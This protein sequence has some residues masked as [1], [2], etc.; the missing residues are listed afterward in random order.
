MSC[1]VRDAGH[2]INI[3]MPGLFY[4]KLVDTGLFVGLAGF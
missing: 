2:S 3:L 1:T 4:A